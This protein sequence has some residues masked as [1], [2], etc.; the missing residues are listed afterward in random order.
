MTRITTITQKINLKKTPIYLIDGSSFIYRAFYAFQDLKTKD[1]FPTNALFIIM[2]IILKILK[3]E[4]PKYACFII[5][6]KGPTFR[7]EIESTYKA[8]RLKMPEPLSMQIPAILKGVN[9]LGITTIIAEHAEADDYIASLCEVF[10][11][12]MPIII[13]GSD[14]DLF[15]LLDKNVILWDPSK[16]E[17]KIITLE[18]FKKENGIDPKSWPLYQALVGDSTDNIK[19]VPGIGPKTAINILK[20]YPSLAQ[21]KEN[22]N[23]LPPKEYK[24]LK[25][26]IENIEKYLALT[27]LKKDIP[28]E[29]KITHYTI[30]PASLKELNSF[31]QKYEF[32]S[33]LKEINSEILK[34]TEEH[35]IETKKVSLSKINKKE[36]GI[37]VEKETLVIG[38]REKE[39][40]VH[41]KKEASYTIKAAQKAFTPSL[42]ELLYHLDPYSLPLKNILDISLGAYLIDPEIR[43]YSLNKLISLYAD[44][45]ATGQGR[46]SQLLETG[47]NIF[48]ILE[49][50][51]L[52]ELYEKIERPLVPVLITMEKNGVKIDSSKFRDFL[53]EV[54]KKLKE[55]SRRIYL[56]AGEEFNIRSSKQ[57][58]EI[59]FKKMGLK[60]GKK[61][62]K[63]EPST[64]SEVLEALK[65]Q[66]PII[67]DIL[68]YRKLEKLRS[69]YLSPLPRLADK[70]NRIHTHFNQLATATGRLSSSNPNLQNIPIRGEFGPK[71]RSCFVAEKGNL[72][73][74][75]DYSQIELRVLAHFSE[76]PYLVNAFFN[77]MDIH[78]STAAALFDKD[79]K[80]ITEDERR[81][82]KTINF[83]LIY[84]M[85]P[86]KLSRE[87]GISIKEAKKFI[88]IYFSKLTGVK[89]F[90]EKV[91]SEA[92]QNGFV[93]T[94]GGRRRYLPNINS[95]NNNLASQ[96]KRMA[97]NTVIQGSA[98]DIIKMS[99]LDIDNNIELKKMGVKL[100]LQIHD[101]L[102]FECPKEN[103]KDAGE[104]ISQIMNSVVKLKVPLVVDL[105]IGENW[106]EAH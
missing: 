51:N 104:I 87:L 53:K 90:F 37:I 67:E 33:L 10:K 101:E 18:N 24:K 106:S 93:S 80:K 76:D 1:G 5:D 30:T 58:S 91:E 35:K 3:Q 79:P 50:N 14:K 94:L 40:L 29:P 11:S 84:G 81:K 95:Q 21:L 98:A 61:T 105:G 71:M 49:Q 47:K 68:S 43:D 99:M 77:G 42:K 48:N 52:F 57:L 70:N 86:Q 63:G 60:P 28:V 62:P 9:L 26:Q 17:E 31:L 66:H 72:L 4:K 85:G 75:A 36:I 8:N 23:T 12:K 22:L 27:T 20:K 41:D 38:D 39:A 73:I 55:L 44:R 34:K 56:Q 69:T 54:E 15:Q 82:A 88:E 100:L 25:D 74:S 32:K 96:A 65:S 13:V 2:R 46:L 102:L 19:G 103:A 89:D 92:K 64:A 97:I 45:S 7:H 16:K 83:G 59:L 6:G 78:L